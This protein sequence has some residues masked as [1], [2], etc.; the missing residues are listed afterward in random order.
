MKNIRGRGEDK[1][2][3]NSVSIDLGQVPAIGSVRRK[4]TVD[5]EGHDGTIVEERDDKNHE[6]RE[7][8]LV[9]KGEDGEADD[10]TDGDGTSVNGVVTHTLEDDTRLADGVDDGGE[11]GLSQDDIGGTTSSIGSTLDGNTDIGTGQG[12]SVV[13]TVTSH[14]AQ[15]TKGLDTLDNL[16][17]VLGEDTSET[18]GIHDHLVEVAVLGT[19]G[20]SVLQHLGGVHVVTET[21]T[22]TGFLCNSELVT[23]NHLDLDTE[24]EGIVDSLLGIFTGRIEDGKQADKL[25]AIAF[26]LKVVTV[27]LFVGN[28]EGTE[29]TSSVLLNISLETVL[30]FVGLVACAEFDDDTGHAL[31][32][33]LEL[34]GGVLAVGDLGT[35]VDGVEWLEIEESDSST[36]LGGITEGTD[37]TGIDGILVLGTRSVGG[38]EDDILSGE[39]AVCPDGVAVDG[40]LVGGE[41]TGLVRAEDGDTSQLFDG[42]DTGDNGLVLGEL[43]STD[44]KGDGKDSGHGNGNTTDQEDEDVVQTATVLIAEAGIE[45]EDL[46]NDED[47]DGNEAE[48]PNLGENLL[49]M[50]SGIIVLT[51][52]GSGTTEESVGSSRD[53]DTLGF[54]V[55]AS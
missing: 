25:K 2:V 12:R 55:L 3:S 33:T 34:A 40:E 30:D 37:D 9:D 10:D 23:S 35:L 26:S 19:R 39:G 18:V 1:T 27:K 36:G 45:D 42:S 52:E 43:L 44:G 32:D 31:G 28:G 46:S 24:G 38:E 20:R 47:T 15:V 41:G 14:G 11:T 16:V 29:T 8:E 13:G 4:D 49:Q 21:E 5:G 53:N 7:V 22:T 17:L 51:D 6:R 54:T 48:R 50:A